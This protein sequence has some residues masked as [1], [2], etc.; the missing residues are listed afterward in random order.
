MCCYW[1]VTFC[2]KL[3]RVLCFLSRHTYVT[4]YQQIFFLFSK[5]KF[6]FKGLQFETNKDIQE[7]HIHIYVWFRKTTTRTV[8]RSGSGTGSSAS[9]Q[10]RSILM[11]ITL[12]RL[13]VSSVCPKKFIKKVL[14]FFEQNL[15]FSEFAILHK[16]YDLKGRW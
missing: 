3:T 13:S 2:P 12:T 5:L 11:K 1:F 10:Q 9:F 6:T 4:W 15:Y 8:S 7:N 14:E 16:P